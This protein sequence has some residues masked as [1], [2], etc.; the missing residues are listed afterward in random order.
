MTTSG[1]AAVR[2]FGSGG[3]RGHRRGRLRLA[4]G[5][6]CVVLLSAATLAGPA[7]TGAGAATT[8]YAVAVP[9][10][11]PAKPGHVTCLAMKL[12]RTAATT[13]GAVAYATG[14]GASTIGPAGGLTPG[15]LASVYG[16]APNAS[17]S[18]QT[19]AVIDWGNDPTIASD[20]ATFDAEYGL[21]VCTKTNGCLSVLNQTGA[22][23]PLPSDQGAAIEISLDVEAVH[24]V[25]PLCKIDLIEVDSSSFA[26]TGAGVN[27]AVAL[28]ATEV[29]NSY[30]GADTGGVPAADTKDY[31]HAGVVIT[32]STGDDGY[33]GFD[34][35]IQTRSG[36]PA[37]NPS[38]PDWPA[39]LGTVVAVGGT[40]LYLNQ[41]GTRQSETVWN[42]NGAKDHVEEL[43]GEPMGASGGGCSKFVT[44]PAWQQKLAAW[45]ET[46]C[47]TKRL[48]ADVSAV[49]DPYTGFDVYDTSDGGTGWETIGGTSLSSPVVA[50]MFALA[51]GAHGITYPALTLY[52]HL[53]GSAL[54]DVTTGGTG[55]CG[56]MG[57]A[58]CGNWNGLSYNGAPLGV[59]DCDYSSTGT[60]VS[61]GDLAC[62][63]DVGYDGPTGVGT[64]VGL[65]AFARV[66]PTAT[67]AGPTT[68]A[69][70]T[71][72]TWTATA[73][74]PFP[75]G[76][77]TTYTWAWGDGTASTVTTTGTASHVYAT[78]GSRTV[79]LTMKDSYGVT[80]TAKHTVTAS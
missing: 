24:S 36:G 77:V 40:S 21:A 10:C 13:P 69:H 30:G 72:G 34:H 64:P 73:K 47:G 59:L 26:D 76:T 19:V 42:Q 5:A 57:A 52:G 25:C 33:Y 9:L 75:A 2:R 6:A 62:D 17:G 44:A 46:A 53:G 68:I 11:P 35:W 74:D 79:T 7:A 18:G 41:N 37:A 3:G 70:G 38:A 50:A 56:G 1:G 67:I 29:T 20:L 71:S 45:P 4:L 60:T 39:E 8:Q 78:A 12:V 61:A 55:F 16:L 14:A 63:A 65:G 22:T 66:G 43:V 32:V 31:N 15:D 80:G 51:G 49:A 28:G 23:A 54:Y 27:E 48:D 58:Q